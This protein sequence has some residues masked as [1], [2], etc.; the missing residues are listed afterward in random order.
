MPVCS[1]DFLV[2]QINDNHSYAQRYI[3]S[4]QTLYVD[5]AQ[6]H[7]MN[8]TPSIGNSNSSIP[9]FCFFGIFFSFIFSFVFCISL[10]SFA[11]DYKKTQD[12]IIL[13][14]DKSKSDGAA[15]LQLKILSADIVHVLAYPDN[16]SKEPIRLCVENKELPQVVFEAKRLEDKI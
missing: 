1:S 3:L 7:D 4:G 6:S 13:E 14:L 2:V 12:G 9:T 10:S 5:T 15:K 8:L 11:Q 16:N